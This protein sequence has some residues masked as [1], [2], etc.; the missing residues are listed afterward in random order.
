MYFVSQCGVWTVAFFLEPELWSIYMEKIKDAFYELYL[1]WTVYRSHF[2]GKEVFLGVWRVALFIKGTISSISL[3]SIGKLKNTI[4]WIVLKENGRCG[5]F[6]LPTHRKVHKSKLHLWAY[7]G[8]VKITW[9][10]YS[11]KKVSLTFFPYLWRK[12]F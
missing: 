7:C 11:T 12:Y 3:A 5:V 2:G 1:Y 8:N 10:E 4:N 6:L 9:V